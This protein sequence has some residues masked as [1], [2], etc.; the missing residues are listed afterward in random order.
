VTLPNGSQ[1]A[2][3]PDNQTALIEAIIERFCAA[4]APGGAVIHLGDRANMSLHFETDSL[5]SLGATLDSF[6]RVP[7]VM[8]HH[9]SKKRLFL[10]E[11]V[12]NA[13]PIDENR[14]Q[15]LKKLFE[16]CKAELV[17]VTAFETRLTMQPFLAHIAWESEVWIAEEPDHMIHFNGERFLGPYPDVLPK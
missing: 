5:T 16:N 6:A 10:I 12:T 14:R 9:V 7:D 11:A 13:G 1:L 15:E 4:F 3:S 17:F 8:V 2:P